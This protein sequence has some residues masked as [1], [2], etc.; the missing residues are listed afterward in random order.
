MGGV[1]LMALKLARVRLLSTIICLDIDDT[2]LNMARAEGAHYTFNTL[3]R[4]RTPHC[5]LTVAD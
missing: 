3:V 2:K 4:V 1:G 5:P